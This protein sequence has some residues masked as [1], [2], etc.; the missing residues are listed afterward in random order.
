MLFPVMVCA[1][2]S[3]DSTINFARTCAYAGVYYNNALLAPEVRGETGG[4]FKTELKEYPYMYKMTVINNQT[5]RPSKKIGFRTS[6]GTRPILFDAPADYIAEHTSEHNSMIPYL[7]LIKEL[8]G[9]LV[10]KKGRPDHP[11]KGTTDSI[12]AFGIGLYVYQVDST[13]I[14]NNKRTQERTNKHI[15]SWYEDRGV[16]SR[17]D[18]SKTVFKPR[19]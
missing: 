15:E 16:P 4:V 10:G 19:R 18:K 13:Q 17:N 8:M 5:N 12:I 1:C 7:P 3:T 14:R 11:K 9:C 6:S 2:R